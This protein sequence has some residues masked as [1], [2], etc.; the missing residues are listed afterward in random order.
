MAH[1]MALSLP[2]LSAPSTASSTR[3]SGVPRRY[4]E[5]KPVMIQGYAHR[6]ILGYYHL[7]LKILLQLFCWVW[8]YSSYVFIQASP[9]IL[10]LSGDS[11]HPYFGCF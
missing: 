6:K 2:A 10:S 5:T 4:E 8:F 1:S 11:V 7:F 3:Y 9:V